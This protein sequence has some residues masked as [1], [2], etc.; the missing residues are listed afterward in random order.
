M[1]AT[2]QLSITGQQIKSQYF[3]GEE[4][5]TPKYFAQLCL[6]TYFHHSFPQEQVNK[7]ELCTLVPQKDIFMLTMFS[8]K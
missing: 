2:H 6:E 4:L 7:T 5:S 8:S 1:H 3:I